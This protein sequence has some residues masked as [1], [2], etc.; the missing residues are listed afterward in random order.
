MNFRTLLLTTAALAIAAPAYAA[1]FGV[2]PVGDPIYAPAPLGV[3]GHL[4]LGIGMIGDGDDSLGNFAAAGRVNIPFAGDWNLE[5]ET[6]GGALTEDGFSAS[7]I[8]AYGHL[9]KNLGSTRLGALGGINYSYG[10]LTSAIVGVEGEV[11]FNAVTLGAQATYSWL[12]NDYDLDVWGLRGWAD[13][14]V[15]PNTK[16]G[17]EVAWTNVSEGSDS[18]DIWTVGVNAEHRF[19]GTPFSG[20]ARVGYTSYFSDFDTWSGMVGVRVFMDQPGTTLRDHDRQ[21][22]FDV[23]GNGLLPFAG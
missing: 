6:G 12:I 3:V 14:Y 22:P 13:W 7:N 21:V 8:G 2:P 4:E 19:A 20:F 23:R 16:V 1:D 5:I 17:A 9:W 11:E 18:D 15:N 10:P